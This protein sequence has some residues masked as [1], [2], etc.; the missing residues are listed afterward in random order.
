[1]LRIMAQKWE[2]L[3]NYLKEGPKKAVVNALKSFGEQWEQL[4]GMQKESLQC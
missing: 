1:M 3:E 4:G 2:L